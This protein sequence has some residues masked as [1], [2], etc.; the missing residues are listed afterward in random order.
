[1]IKSNKKL[2]VKIFI[3]ILIISILNI[4]SYTRIV[5]NGSGMGYCE[6]DDKSSIKKWKIKSSTIT[7]YIV[8]GAGYYLDA[9]SHFISFLNRVELSE[10]RGINYIEWNQLVNRALDNIKYAKETYSLLIEVAENTPYNQT[11]ISKLKN[12][13]YDFYMNENK[14]NSVIFTKLENYL[15]KGDIR[16][17]HKRI[18]SDVIYIEKLLLSIKEKM[19][20][21][22]MPEL[23]ILWEL[24]E[25]FSDTLIF[26]QYSSRVFHAIL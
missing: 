26:G 10:T 24:N 8:D 5:H 12:F 16:G 1:M 6:G 15:K 4:I 3:G 21:D 13:D 19:S 9:Y 17:I 14:L 25:T 23:S 11:V 22:K 7:A 2:V 20:L 18:Y